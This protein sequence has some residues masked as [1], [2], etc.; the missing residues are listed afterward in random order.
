[1]TSVGSVSTKLIVNAIDG[2]QYT[3]PIHSAVEPAD[4][5]SGVTGGASAETPPEAPRSLAAL[6]ADA[7]ALV[8]SLEA[9]ARSAEP[10]PLALAVRRS[11]TFVRGVSQLTG[12]PGW[13]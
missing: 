1:M 11:D 3:V 6:I 4:C 13:V 9:E 10:H 2:R 7:K 8:A 12:K 5:G